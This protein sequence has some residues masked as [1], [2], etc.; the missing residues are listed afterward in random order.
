MPI[1]TFTVAGTSPRTRGKPLEAS[2]LLLAVR[3]IPAH[4]GKT[5]PTYTEK[6]LSAEHP[7]ARGENVAMP[8][9]W[10]VEAGTSPRT[11]GKLEAFIIIPEEDRNIP[12]HAGKTHFVGGGS[13]SPAEH[14]RARGENRVSRFLALTM[15]GTSPRTR[16]KLQLT[17][18]CDGVAGN[19]PAHA[20]K[21]AV[22][23]FA[24]DQ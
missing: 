23:H 11:R 6:T 22:M 21:T 5:A 13:T 18:R 1:C 3:N 12:A 2:D 7:R 4:A 14:P 24:F 10:A 19:I 15:L 16:G 17:V 8:A 20:G 9:A